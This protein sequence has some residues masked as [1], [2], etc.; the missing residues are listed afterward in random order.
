MAAS[1]PPPLPP[2][3]A[4]TFSPPRPSPPVQRY[5]PR[6]RSRAG[7]GVGVR[8]SSAHREPARPPCAHPV[9]VPFPRPHPVLSQG[10]GLPKPALEQ[11]RCNELQPPR[12]LVLFRQ[13]LCR[14]ALGERQRA[15]HACARNYEPRKS[16]LRYLRLPE[17]V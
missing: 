11:T 5:G 16:A 12:K 14:A 15:P 2:P 4:P 13:A 17:G 1:P 6:T 3:E 9:R 8:L 10:P 7:P